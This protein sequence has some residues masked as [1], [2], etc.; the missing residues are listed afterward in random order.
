[1]RLRLSELIKEHG[2]VEVTSGP[3]MATHPFADMFVPDL[4]AAMIVE[5]I[6][7]WL[8]QEQPYTPEELATKVASL[9]SAVFREASAWA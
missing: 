7:L 1:M 9:V 8:E 5:A 3:I 4:V 2:S 6:T